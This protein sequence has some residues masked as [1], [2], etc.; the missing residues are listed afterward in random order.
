MVFP[1]LGEVVDLKNGKVTLQDS[2]IWRELP[3]SIELANI[4]SATLLQPL[5]T[6]YEHLPIAPSL[7]GESGSYITKLL[8]KPSADGRYFVVINANFIDIGL[9]AYVSGSQTRPQVEVFS[10]LAD[11]ATP[12][13][14]HFQSVTVHQGPID[15]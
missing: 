1:V 12:H 13:L 7:G 6:G 14:L 9:S 4:A 10:Q 3:A 15:S 2:H 8:L 5:Q 11:D